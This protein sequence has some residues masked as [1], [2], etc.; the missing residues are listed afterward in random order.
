MVRGHIWDAWGSLFKLRNI[1]HFSLLE[2]LYI[3]FP[4]LTTIE[5]L[6]DLVNLEEIAMPAFSTAGQFLLGHLLR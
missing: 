5:I 4:H 1:T 2:K 6:N 3:Y